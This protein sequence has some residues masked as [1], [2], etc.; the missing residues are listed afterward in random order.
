[1]KGKAN[2][3]QRQV[4]LKLRVF[5]RHNPGWIATLDNYKNSENSR[6]KPIQG[7]Q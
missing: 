4:N 3:T 6:D 2:K 5:M 7:I 1:M